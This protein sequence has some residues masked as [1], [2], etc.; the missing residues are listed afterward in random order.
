MD[1]R[2]LEFCLAGFPIIIIIARVNLAC[3]S[4][5]HGRTYATPGAVEHSQ[6]AYRRR[7]LATGCSTYFAEIEEVLR[8]LERCALGREYLDL[9]KMH[10]V[11]DSLKVKIT[12]RTRFNVTILLR[13][14]MVGLFLLQVDAGR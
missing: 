11:L 12:P 6:R 8:Q 10:R 2:L 9:P 3:C 1:K 13:G 5:K 7:I 4:G 14:L